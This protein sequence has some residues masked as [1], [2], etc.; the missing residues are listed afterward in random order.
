ME[1][2]DVE[3]RGLGVESRY[4]DTYIVRSGWETNRVS[5]GDAQDA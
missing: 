1:R 3:G 4:A 5:W 2:D